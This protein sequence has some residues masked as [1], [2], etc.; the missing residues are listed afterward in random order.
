M[1]K[2]SV[3]CM[4]S[5]LTI[6]SLL[7][8]CG[9]NNVSIPKPIDEV[10]E[11]ESDEQ[12]A[13]ENEDENTLSI[14]DVSAKDGV[15][16]TH[17]VNI[18]DSLYE[19]QQKNT[20]LSEFSLNT[21]LGLVMQG[22][23]GQT[24]A[25]FDDYFKEIKDKSERD[26]ELYRAYS[27]YEDVDIHVANG[28]YIDVN[29]PLLTEFESIAKQKYFAGIDNVD[30]HGD[31]QGTADKINKFCDENTNHKI[32]EIINADTV[33]QCDSVLIN[34]LYFNGEWDEA[35]EYKRLFDMDFNNVDGSI[36]T[37]TGMEEYG[38][39]LY[40]V[41]DTLAFSKMYKGNDFE[42]IGILPGEDICSE[43]GDF[44]LCDI[45][46]ETLLES[47]QYDK[48]AHIKMPKFV[49]EDN[50]SLVSSLKSEGLSSAF[51]VG[52]TSDFTKLA[53]TDMCISDVIQKTYVDVSEKGTEAAAI[54][55]IE[56][57]NDACAI[58]EPVEVVDVILDRPFVFMIYDRV[59]D[60]ILFIGKMVDMN[61]CK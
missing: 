56:M 14:N 47:E 12:P 1:K 13:D 39:S 17:A 31:S 40:Q 38:L 29:N 55:V 60:E 5:A 8:G 44:S 19:N 36:K 7:A 16:F 53:L 24:R 6:A 32:L 28:I 58:E 2:K 48:S 50:N 18:I 49:V 61:S 10:Q 30:F 4:L 22:S 54:T 42:F 20:V 35:F 21:A 59:N 26:L 9:G 46:F 33:N 43:N 52:S 15:N 25:E 3:L 27:S 57:T 41:G 51:E 37:V 45:P 11:V 23:D 34:A